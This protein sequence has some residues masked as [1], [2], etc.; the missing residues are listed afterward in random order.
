MTKLALTISIA[1]LAVAFQG[2]NAAEFGRPYEQL[3]VDL[4]LPN[5]VDPAPAQ[6]RGASGAPFEDVELERAL[7][8]FP[9]RAPRAPFTRGA[10]YE[11]LDIDRMLPSVPERPGAGMD[12]GIDAEAWEKAHGTRN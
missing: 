7:P 12:S 2:A 3:D 1:A 5:V 11:D 8:Q 4:A 10:P 9:E 6:Q